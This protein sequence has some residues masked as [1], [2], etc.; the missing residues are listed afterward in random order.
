M[1]KK[2]GKLKKT[3]KIKFCFLEK[4]FIN[5]TQQ[6][7]IM[8]ALKSFAA[9]DIVTTSNN[10]TTIVNS[11]L[12]KS[13]G[14]IVKHNEQLGYW[15]YTD[16]LPSMSYDHLFKYIIIGPSGNKLKTTKMLVKTVSQTWKLKKTK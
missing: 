9:F 6:T 4:Q 11:N 10:S 16:R 12:Q 7:L 1:D 13:A 3:K 15:G 8:F 2:F 5:K 14:N